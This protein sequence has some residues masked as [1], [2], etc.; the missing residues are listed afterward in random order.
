[1]AIRPGETVQLLIEKPAAGGRM[2]A[3]VDGQVVLVVGVIPGERVVARIE[4]IAK[5]VAFAQAL[6]IDEPS[7]DRREPFTDPLCG[8][9]LYAHIAYARQI[10]IKEQVV[11]DAFGRIGHITLPGP[12]HVAPSPD[13]GYRMRARV[14]LRGHRL[15]FFREGTHDICDVRSTRQLLSSTCDVLDQI[16]GKIRSLGATGGELEV[17][18]NVD[19]SRRVV[20]V[21]GPGLDPQVISR[22]AGTK[23]LTGLTASSSSIGTEQPAV[24][25]GD[26]YVV[27]VVSIEGQAI[28][29]RRHVLAFFQGNRF[30]LERLT[31]H[32]VAQVGAGNRVL[33]LYAGAGL[34]SVSSAIVRGA[35]VTAVEGDRFAAADLAANAADSGGATEA[36]H[37]PVEAF[38]AT[39]HPSPDVLIADP[40]RTGMS[41]AAISGAIALRPRKVVYVSCDVA[42]LARDARKLLDAGYEL[43]RIDAFDLFPNTPHV[44]CV[45]VFTAN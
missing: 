5:G 45:A 15:G 19:A 6:S 12:V 9:C 28:R 13:E 44:E 25:A 17:S 33:D 27:D 20:H 7:S 29:L 26:P 21:Q 34:F 35:R 41:K 30:W 31:A 42:T 24:V 11:A 16:G 22:V 38:L 43:D 23:G 3:R 36:V 18:E 14:H 10:A 37:Q 1:M 32:V 39:P 2:I 4:Q 40:P 8:G